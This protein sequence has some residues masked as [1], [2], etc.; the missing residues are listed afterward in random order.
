MRVFSG[1][2]TPQDTGGDRLCLARWLGSRTSMSPMTRFVVYGYWKCGKLAGS[3]MF[4]SPLAEDAPLYV[5]KPAI[6]YS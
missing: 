2:E 3:Q 4:G 5:S 1:P 6:G